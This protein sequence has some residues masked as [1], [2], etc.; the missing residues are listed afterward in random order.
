MHKS[1]VSTD[2][3]IDPVCWMRV[4]AEK[5]DLRATHLMRTYYFCSEA[6]R[7]A[8]EANPEAY[9]DSKP[10]GHAG[11]WKLSLKR[12]GKSISRKPNASYQ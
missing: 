3:F 4:R 10:S 9:L 6:C 5:K 1:N 11:W 12:L 8:F 7:K 2:I